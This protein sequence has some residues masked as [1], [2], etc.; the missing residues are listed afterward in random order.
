[1]PT[2]RDLLKTLALG[3]AG[4][5]GH[6]RAHAASDELSQ[7]RLFGY[8]TSRPGWNAKPYRVGN[9][10]RLRTF[11]P[12]NVIRRSMTPQ[13]I[14][15][16]SRAVLS[17][18]MVRRIQEYVDSHPVTG[19]LVLRRG[20]L[21][22][23][24]YQYDRT[25]HDQ[26]H[27]WSMSKTILGLAVGVAIADGL[28]ASIQ[29]TADKYVPAL[30]GTLHGSTRIKDLL[31]MSSG[32]DVIHK[33]ASEGGDLE[34]IYNQQLLTQTA[35]SLEMVRGWNKRREPAGVRFNYNELAPI[36]LAHVVIG[37][38]GASLSEYVQKRIWERAGCEDDASWITDSK[39][40]EF[41]CIGL[42]AT[43][44]DWAR[45]G[46]LMANNG[47]I[48]DEQVVPREWLFGAT[49]VAPEDVHL[50]SGALP[51]TRSGYG[52]LVWIDGYSRRRVFSMRGHQSQ[53]VVVAPDSQLVLAQT[54][55]ESDYGDFHKSMY[56][57]FTDLLSLAD[58][59]TL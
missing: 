5:L 52:Y 31:Q 11:F 28:I 26:L 55:V 46:L 8:P 45:I 50:R 58:S 20:Q 38:S 13:P 9:F 27:G 48:R 16:P 21:V 2:R 54:A 12:H 49:T 33:L 53:F 23:E 7:G 57:I 34:R 19:F 15:K 25:R 3:G 39:G 43:L 47:T 14:A 51:N 6:T 41:G 40:K 10:S 35:D 18:A 17:E 30:S 32:A 22:F 29:D 36:T 37:A 56:G 24:A 59:G 42:S 4:L 44:R 1:M